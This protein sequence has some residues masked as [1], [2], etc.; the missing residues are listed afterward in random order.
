[1]VSKSFVIFKKKKASKIY[2]NT[3]FATKQSYVI[4]ITELLLRDKDFL[5]N[6]TYSQTLR[7]G[8]VNKV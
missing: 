2:C 7:K 4:F 5:L 6:S 8:I 1:M 3:Y